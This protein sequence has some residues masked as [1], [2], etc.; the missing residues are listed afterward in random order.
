M[1]LK[2]IFPNSLLVLTELE[3]YQLALLIQGFPRINPDQQGFD[4]A[5]F[6]VI[7]YCSVYL[8]QRLGRFLLDFRANPNE[9]GIA[10]IQNLPMD[11]T[12]EWLLMLLMSF[13]A[14]LV[15]EQHA[16]GARYLHDM[17][18]GF[19][20]SFCLDQH[21]YIGLLCLR[22]GRNPD[23]MTI[24]SSLQHSKICYRLQVGDMLLID[25]QIIGSEV[26][27]DGTGQWLRCLAGVRDGR[28]LKHAA[29]C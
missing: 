22:Q 20:R 1:R 12:S 27:Y 6:P 8:P 25:N 3:K 7:R 10:L 15:A 4:K 9:N 16:E 18:D 24:V 26:C 21:D 23:D 19:S 28:R 29:A 14:D 5:L 17:K 13:I 11:A 2:N